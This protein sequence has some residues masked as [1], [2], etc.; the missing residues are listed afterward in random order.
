LAV[1]VLKLAA[2]SFF[3]L[4]VAALGAA[5]VLGSGFLGLAV[6]LVAVTFGCMDATVTG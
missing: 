3:G 6:L 4:T 1:T 2:A 5:V